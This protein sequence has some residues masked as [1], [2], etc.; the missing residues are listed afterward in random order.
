MNGERVL[1][2]RSALI[3][4]VTYVAIR[5]FTDML[6]GF[7]I[8]WDAKTRTAVITKGTHVVTATVGDK[9]VYAQGR[10]FY[11]VEPIMIIE[12]SMFLPVRA[13][14]KA[15][16]VEVSWDNTTRSVTLKNTG[17]LPRSGSDF[18]NADDLYWLSRIISAEAQGESL[19][20]QIAVGTRY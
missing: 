3:N 13:I 15:L 7:E 2:G 5:D 19:L 11:T 16:G 17:V 14:A 8:S 4:S 10:C 12:D 18:Y 9:Y 20:G 1:E 6:G